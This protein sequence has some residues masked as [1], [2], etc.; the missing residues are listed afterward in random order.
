VRVV[1]DWDGTATARDTLWIA[2][3]QFGDR[4]VF[5]RSE[6]SLAAGRLS[7]RE[8]MEAEMGTISAPL[9]DVIGY[10][11][12]HVRMRPGFRELVAAHRPLILSSG[13]VEL[14]E[15]I[16]A[17]EGVQ[18]E[19]RA[20]RLEPAPEGW[21]VVWRDPAPCVVCGD[22]CKRSALPPGPVAYVGDGYSDRCAALAADRVFAT[23]D[24]A[25]YLDGEGVA[26]ER[27]GDLS[28]VVAALGAPA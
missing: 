10:L 15:P 3:E 19:L 20:N 16:L 27:F 28:D 11:V 4:D 17:R 25:A 23:R 13:Y 21:R 7:Y 5:E 14:I 9:G 2:L 24:L 18:V 8:L 22:A 6:R 26:H 12:E 1:L